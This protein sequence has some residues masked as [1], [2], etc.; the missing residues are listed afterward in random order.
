MSFYQGLLVA[1]A[2]GGK[3]VDGVGQNCGIILR[4]SIVAVGLVTA[5]VDL[6]V[7]VS[8]AIGGVGVLIR[9]A[10]AAVGIITVVAIIG[11]VEDSAACI[12]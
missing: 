3:L 8:I 10:R 6:D 4:H 9:G 5:G 2:L 1:E 7:V 11:K 12:D